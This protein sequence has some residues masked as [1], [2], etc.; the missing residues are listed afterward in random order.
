MDVGMMS[1]NE[2]AELF[3]LVYSPHI[4]HENKM[5]VSSQSV[6]DTLSSSIRSEHFRHPFL[7]RLLV[8]PMILAVGDVNVSVLR[9]RRGGRMACVG[10]A[11]EDELKGQQVN[12]QLHFMTSRAQLIQLGCDEG[13]G[14]GFVKPLA[15]GDFWA[16]TA[17]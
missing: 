16:Y 14:Y 8:A 3:T 7:H 12:L 15:P 13:Q 1:A 6:S 5:R 2:L 10:F 11:L 4:E 9:S 17:R